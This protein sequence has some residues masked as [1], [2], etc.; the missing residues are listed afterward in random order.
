MI[1][2]TKSGQQLLGLTN[3]GLSGLEAPLSVRIGKLRQFKRIQGRCSGHETDPF[4]GAEQGASFCG[5]LCHS[6]FRA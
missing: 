1:G 4:P 5:S 6:N 3:S 2:G